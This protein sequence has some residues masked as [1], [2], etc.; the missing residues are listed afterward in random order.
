[1]E[2]LTLTQAIL[3][4]I[5]CLILL[6]VLSFVIINLAVFRTPAPDCGNGSSKLPKLSVL[7]P[8]R[9]EERSI[10]ACLSS[11]AGQDYPN[12]E[13]I[14][15]DDGSTDRTAEIARELGFDMH[16]KL[17]ISAGDPLPSGWTGKGW[18]CH[19]LSQLASGD[20]LLFTDADTVH[21]PGSLR[22]IIKFAI[23]QQADLC[24]AWPRQIT[25]TLAEKLIIPQIYLLVLGFLPQ[26]LLSLFQRFTGLSRLLPTSLLR[27]LGAANG[28]FMLF[29][30][31]AYDALGGHA[32]VKNHLVEDVALGR[33]VAARTADGMRLINCDGSR[34]VSCR[35]YQSIAEVWEGFTKN[36]RQ[37]FEDSLAT[38]LVSL[39]VQFI[40]FILPFFIVWL[41]GWW[42]L[43]GL[44]QIATVY[45][46]RGLLAAR[47]HGSWLSVLLHPI[48]HGFAL[49]IALNSW[50]RWA[51]SQV[52]WK[53]RDY[54]QQ[55]LG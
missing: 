24:S 11:L 54:S 25:G 49:A 6:N 38:F 30:R 47:F 36:L 19:Q 14:L 48:G 15:L 21:Q 3:L 27:S 4:A 8:A 10:K 16:G 46:I 9:N 18:A 52:R 40:G 50:R 7:V 44:L 42:T 17:R 55:S 33:A 31:S 34:I 29:Q 53:D 35:M 1:M 12:L 32:S 23:D 26:F 45:L 43:G 5:P 2:P 13:I 39:S 22:S 20:W 51:G 41:G 37:A 28:Q